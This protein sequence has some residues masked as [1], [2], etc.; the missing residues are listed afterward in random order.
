MRILEVLQK[1]K[2]DKPLAVLCKDGSTVGPGSKVSEDALL[3]GAKMFDTLLA[4][5]P[6]RV[7]DVTPEPP[8]ASGK[9]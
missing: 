3:G 5:K 1:S 9:K 4:E 2:S 6:P 7:K 8:K